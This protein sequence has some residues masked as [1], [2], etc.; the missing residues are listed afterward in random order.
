[1]NIAFFVLWV[2]IIILLIFLI[3][4]STV[5]IKQIEDSKNTP[6]VLDTTAANFCY[7]NGNITALPEVQRQFPC[8]ID[9]I[10]TTKY[11]FNDVNFLNNIGVLVDIAPVDYLSA[12]QGFCGNYDVI[13]GVCQDTK[14]NNPLYYNCLSQTKPV[15][16]CTQKAMPIAY[17]D[18]IPY[19]LVQTNQINCKGA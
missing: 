7:P 12:C 5:N 17:R 13:Q 4:L 2:I 16:K 6:F 18:N 11:P 10:T 9:G 3:Y 14:Q 1:M 8:I 15:G 19:Y